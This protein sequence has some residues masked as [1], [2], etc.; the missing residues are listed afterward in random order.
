MTQSL[1]HRDASHVHIILTNPDQND[2]CSGK[3]MAFDLPKALSRREAFPERD[4]AGC[5]GIINA[6]GQPQPKLLL[7]RELSSTIDAQDMPNEQGG[8]NR[9][10]DLQTRPLVTHHNVMLRSYLG[11]QP[12]H[13]LV[14]QS[15]HLPLHQLRHGRR[16][17][18]RNWY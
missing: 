4:G 13:Q 5:I 1:H 7:S 8:V 15:G 17:W 16:R 6:Q 12:L 2:G 3:L 9:S 18:P 11:H 10:I 14:H